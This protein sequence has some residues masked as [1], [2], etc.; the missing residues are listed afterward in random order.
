MIKVKIDTD[1][2]KLDQLLKLSGLVGSGSQAHMLIE[3]GYVKVNGEVASQKRK[4]IYPKDTVEMDGKI[5]VVASDMNN[6][7]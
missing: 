5:L 6:D 1:Y 2:I 3:D 7:N 4:K